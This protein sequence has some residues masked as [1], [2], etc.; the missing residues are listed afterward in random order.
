[1]KTLAVIPSRHESSR[2]PGKPLA[3]I[4]GTPMVE[5]VYRHAKRVP[6]IDRLIVATDNSLIA[7]CV[8]GFGGEAILTSRGCQSGTDRA[9]EVLEKLRKTGDMYDLVINIQ[10]DEPAMHPSVIQGVIDLAVKD[11]T[12]DVLTAACSFQNNSDIFNTNMVK[13]V[14][15]KNRK[16]L[17]FSRSPIPFIRN[18]STFTPSSVGKDAIGYYQCH[19]GIYAF[20][21]EALIQFANLPMDPIE[22]LEKLEQLRVLRQGMSIG[23]AEAQYL[24]IGVDRPEDITSVENL[25]TI[26][27]L[28]SVK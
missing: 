28:Y 22:N 3:P 21:K 24:S 19:L 25:L 9:Y 15:D 4:H 16:A 12:F 2:F 26:N 27:G 8:K 23:V 5:W 1:M 18:N 10:G 17:Y 7:D 14:T 20:R 6:S 11:K 13:V